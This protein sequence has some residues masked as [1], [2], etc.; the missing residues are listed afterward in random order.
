[1]HEHLFV[2]AAPDQPPHG[3]AYAELL[4]L[5]LGDGCVLVL[6]R[7]TE[8][9]IHCDARQDRVIDEAEA[10]IRR[11]LPGR[12]VHRRAHGGDRCVVVSAYSPLWPR[13]L[14]QHGP[15]RKHQ[16]HLVLAH[17]QRHHVERWPW[18]FLRGL[19]HSDGCRSVNRVV[20]ASGTYE[21]AR[22]YF[23]N[24]SDDILALFGWACDLAGVAWTRSGP[25]RISVSRRWSVALLDEHVGP[26]S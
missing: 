3:E 7:A 17:W 8:L 1:V 19:L 11:V 6:P 5:Y 10:A 18:A 16:R 25:R 20:A 12:H 9:R 22:R 13:L 15:G 4:G 23:T 21:Y 24:A 14:P 2:H 26:K